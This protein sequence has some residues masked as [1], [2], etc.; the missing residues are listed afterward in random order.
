MAEATTAALEVRLA[1]AR[2]R[3]ESD[4]GRVLPRGERIGGDAGAN[5]YDQ[6]G[7][8]R[9][10]PRRLTTTLPAASARA[11]R[12]SGASCAN[13]IPRLELIVV[14]YFRNIETQASVTAKRTTAAITMAR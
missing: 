8:E 3:T 4:I 13:L 2:M 9:L 10:S 14:D 11:V 6:S 12:S 1:D 5:D 7:E